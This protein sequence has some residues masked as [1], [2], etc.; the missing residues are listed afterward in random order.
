MTIIQ[1]HL[2]W[3]DLVGDRL[4]LEV[5]DVIH[6]LLSSSIPRADGRTTNGRWEVSMKSR[7]LGDQYT[8]EMTEEI[9]HS[10]R[11]YRDD[12][13]HRSMKFSE[14]IGTR[15][16]RKLKE[17]SGELRKLVRELR[18]LSNHA[19]SL[20]DIKIEDHGKMILTF[21]IVTIISLPLPFVCSYLGMNMADIRS[22]ISTQSPL[23]YMALPL[24]LV[25]MLTAWTLAFQAHWLW[26]MYRSVRFHTVPRISQWV[27]RSVGKE[28]AKM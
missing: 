27:N 2:V 19:E 7:S 26:Q 22:T 12:E 5:L 4:H 8:L 15:Y 17:R 6:S 24:A 10:N 23:W 28:A 3:N 13:E 18:E 9:G 16:L 20:V 1:K 14:E 21:T 11:Y 25:L